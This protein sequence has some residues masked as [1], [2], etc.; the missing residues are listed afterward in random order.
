[1]LREV[2]TVPCT[3]IDS[4]GDAVIIVRAGRD[5]VALCVSLSDGGDA[6]VQLSVADALRARDALNAAIERAGVFTE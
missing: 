3:D 1:M 5:R 2:A 6:E 4:A